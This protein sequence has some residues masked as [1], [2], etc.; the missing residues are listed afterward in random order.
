MLHGHDASCVWAIWIRLALRLFKEGFSIILM[1]LPGY[2]KSTADEKDRV[3][4]KYYMSDAGDMIVSVLDAF[5]IKKV[6]GVGFCGGAANFIRAI[7]AHPHRFAHSHV[8]HNSVIS[9]IPDNFEKELSTYKMRI[10]V[11]W[12]VDPDHIK[13]CVGYKYFSSKSK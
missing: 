1:D 6:H 11:S 5:K 13:Q 10:W 8:F 3:N 12:C 9:A 2:G 7:S 4:P